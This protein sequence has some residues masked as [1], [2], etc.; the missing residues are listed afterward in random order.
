[1]SDI[2]KYINPSGSIR[3]GVQVPLV[4]YRLDDVVNSGTLSDRQALVPLVGVSQLLPHFEGFGVEVFRH[5]NTFGFS[6]YL[7][8]V[9]V[10][11]LANEFVF[12]EGSEFVFAMGSVPGINLLLLF[13]FDGLKHGEYGLSFLLRIYPALAL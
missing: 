5:L 8:V 2:N 7:S 13:G 10:D 9:S 6:Q 1:M 12:E 4:D 3:V 11:L